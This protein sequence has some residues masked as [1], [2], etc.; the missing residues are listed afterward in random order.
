ME[1]KNACRKVIVFMAIFVLLPTNVCINA[2]DYDMNIINDSIM[3]SRELC[4]EKTVNQNEDIKLN[5]SAYN[6]TYIDENI[7]DKNFGFDSYLR[8]NGKFHK[9]KQGLIKF[10][11]SCI[12]ESIEVN[13]AF[14]KLY[15]FGYE[16]EEFDSRVLSV[17]RVLSEWS[18]N[19]TTWESK[20]LVAEY[21]DIKDIKTDFEYI[22]FSVKDDVNYFI[23]NPQYNNGWSIQE[24]GGNPKYGDILFC[25]REFENHE[26]IPILEIEV[27]PNKINKVIVD[28]NIPDTCP[29]LGKLRFKDIES[30]YNRVWSKG[31]I[32]VEPGYYD[33]CIEINKIVNLE[34]NVSRE[35]NKPIIVNSKQTAITFYRSS[36]GSTMTNFVIASNESCHD[37]DPLISIQNVVK[38][39]GL[40][41]GLTITSCNITNNRFQDGGNGKTGI[42]LRNAQQ[43][44]ISDCNVS[45]FNLGIYMNGASLS[46]CMNH[47]NITK[48]NVGIKIE[49][50]DNFII[51]KCKIFRNYVMGI[52]INT[53]D[54]IDVIHCDIVENGLGI[55]FNSYF[56]VLYYLVLL[57]G[58]GRGAG[59]M[60]EHIDGKIDADTKDRSC[61]ENC[62]IHNNTGWA[63]FIFDGFIDASNNYWGHPSGPSGLTLGLYLFGYPI[64]GFGGGYISWRQPQRKWVPH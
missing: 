32:F 4:I 20:P 15:Y 16:G 24:F 9:S 11:L 53:C 45:Y 63:L 56:E 3:L 50:S 61:I 47:C 62:N 27:Q 42:Y 59:I 28:D 5:F 29:C 44:L 57:N 48:N 54:N 55:Q 10:N 49:D 36:N 14:L 39:L 51:D 34:G 7:P 13:K 58:P 41:F 17:N 19:E 1:E 38:P 22:D 52:H 25:S 35:G 46:C 2:Q 60:I 43:V 40:P 21:S 12:P 33:E 37:Y 6:D 8:I 30:A 64:W 31:I 23:A 18:E 26:M